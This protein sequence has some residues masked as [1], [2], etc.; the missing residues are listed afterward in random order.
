MLFPVKRWSLCSR[1]A[2]SSIPQAVCQ[3]RCPDS[4]IRGGQGGPV[5]PNSEIQGGQ[6]EPVDP[7][8]E[9]QGEPVDQGEL[10]SRN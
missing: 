10:A 8:S 9:I 2:F 6:G 7:N 5:D 4:E 1:G 3:A